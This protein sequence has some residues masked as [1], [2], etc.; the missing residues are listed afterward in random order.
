[1]RS[2]NINEKHKGE[3]VGQFA[4]LSG[5]WQKRRQGIFEGGSDTPNAQNGYNQREVLLLSLQSFLS[6]HNHT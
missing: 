2:F 6:Q 1:M 3:L 5:A 4:D